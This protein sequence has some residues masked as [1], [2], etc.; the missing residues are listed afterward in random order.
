MQIP[1]RSLKR[2]RLLPRHGGD[3]LVVVVVAVLLEDDDLLH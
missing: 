1:T 2:D 3:V